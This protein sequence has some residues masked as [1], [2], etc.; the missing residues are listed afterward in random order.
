MKACEVS[1][2]TID[3]IQ[4]MI[5]QNMVPGV[6]EAEGVLENGRNGEFTWTFYPSLSPESDPSILS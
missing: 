1:K 2:C 3:G 5:C 6:F 4:Y